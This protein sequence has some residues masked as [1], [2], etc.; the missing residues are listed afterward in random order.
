MLPRRIALV[1]FK[2]RLIERVD[3]VMSSRCSMVAVVVGLRRLKALAV[4]VRFG[5]RSGG[6]EIQRPMAARRLAI[7]VLMLF[8]PPMFCVTL[9]VCRVTVSPR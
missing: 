5:R 9:S 7:A 4:G 1:V 2:H 8:V 6:L 3:A